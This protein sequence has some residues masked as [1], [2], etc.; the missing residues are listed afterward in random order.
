MAQGETARIHR[1]VERLQAGDESA[2]NE[3]IVHFEQRLRSLTRKM[4]RE[5]PLVQRSEQ[6]D[7]VFQQAVLRLCRALKAVSPGNTRELIRLSAAQ[8]RRELLNLTRYYKSRPSVQLVEQLGPDG[9]GRF[10][11]TVRLDPTPLSQEPATAETPSVLE[12]WTEF[13]QVVATLPEA[14]REVFDLVFYQGMTQSEVASIQDVSL[15]TVRK[16]WNSARL[17]IYDALDGKLPGS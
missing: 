2:L 14:E 16:R 17:A 3:L 9:E 8:V 6:T 4:I 11:Q 13:H 10:S 15:K 12:N 7:D 1:W 5:F